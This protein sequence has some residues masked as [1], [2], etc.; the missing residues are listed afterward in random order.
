MKENN[1]QYIVL[2]DYFV[3]MIK[4]RISLH[5]QRPDQIFSWLTKNK[6]LKKLYTDADGTSGWLAPVVAGPDS[7][8]ATG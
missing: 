4:T 8:V 5:V 7:E 6:I 3:G 1:Q 2:S